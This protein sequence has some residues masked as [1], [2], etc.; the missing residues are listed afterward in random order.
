MLGSKKR[1]SVSG[2]TTLISHETVVIG[3]V[4]FSGNLDVEGLVQ[5]NIIASRVRM[6]CC[7]W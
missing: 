6:H 5:G 4:H 7:G 1:A 3:D 2:G